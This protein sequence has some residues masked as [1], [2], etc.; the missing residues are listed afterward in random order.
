VYRW[1]LRGDQFVN[2]W[3]SAGYGSKIKF[4]RVRTPP[5]SQPARAIELRR[6]EDAACQCV[7]LTFSSAGTWP[8]TATVAV[9]QALP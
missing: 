4:G 5:E 7:E 9:E 6:C 1:F 3:R 2:G 8:P